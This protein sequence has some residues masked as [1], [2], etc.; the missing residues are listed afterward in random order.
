MTMSLG[1][2]R[3]GAA[4]VLLMA[5]MALA[6]CETPGK[7]GE[8]G[9][10]DASAAS[11]E[12]IADALNNDGRVTL[13]GVLFETDSDRL[14]PEGVDAGV[15]LAS[16]MQQHPEIKVAVVGHT[17][18]TGD[19]RYNLGLSQ[20][21]AEALAR[22]LVQNGVAQDRIAPVGVGEIAPVADNGTAEGRAQNRR[23]DVVL[24]E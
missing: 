12:D 16:V 20:R 24:I 13:R 1:I 8:V 7:V 18:S 15:R 14:S 2:L 4:P 3:R 19:F 17:D 22:E 9:I 11:V 6:A 23:V 10:F 21:R 5:T